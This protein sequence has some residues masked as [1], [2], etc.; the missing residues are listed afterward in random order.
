M[1]YCREYIYESFFED[2][3]NMQS[4]ALREIRN[5]RYA[6]VLSSV[7]CLVVSD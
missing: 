3:N 2:V 7:L 6:G 5:F 1:Q 4:F